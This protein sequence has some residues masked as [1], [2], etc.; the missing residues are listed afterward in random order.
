LENVNELLIYAIMLDL[1]MV[2]YVQFVIMLMK[3]QK[4]AK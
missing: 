2:A 4:S 1:L 3:L